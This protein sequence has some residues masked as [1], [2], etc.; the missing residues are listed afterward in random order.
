MRVRVASRNTALQNLGDELDN[1]FVRFYTGPVPTDS[2]TALTGSNTL[3][4]ECALS[5][6]AMG[7]PSGGVRSFN[8][9]GAAVVQNT[10]VPTF[11]RFFLSDGATAVV[12]MDVPREIVLAKSS[13]TA[14]EAFA[15]PSITWN[16]PAECA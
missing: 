13:W 12:D 8:A 2:D 4:V 16:Q 10:G 1:G 11:A 14:G 5:N 7:S 3:V 6:P 15:G 9:I